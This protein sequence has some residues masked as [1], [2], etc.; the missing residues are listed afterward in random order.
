MVVMLR[1]LSLPPSHRSYCYEELCV[2]GQ[3]Y[4]GRDIAGP[5]FSSLGWQDFHGPGLI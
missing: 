3:N 5:N 4:G 1:A 2:T